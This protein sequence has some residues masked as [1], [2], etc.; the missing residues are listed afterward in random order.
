MPL[1]SLPQLTRRNVEGSD[2]DIVTLLGICFEFPPSEGSPEK[3]G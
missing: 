3:L 1:L 2:A